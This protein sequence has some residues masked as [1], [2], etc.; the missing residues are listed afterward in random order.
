MAISHNMGENMGYMR[1]RELRKEAG[2]TQVALGVQVGV[3]QSIVSDWENEVYLPK[4]R[5]L[6]ALA[7]VLGCEISELFVRECEE[8]S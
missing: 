5:D 8:V 7:R 6:P 2:L 3:T 1:I 4:A